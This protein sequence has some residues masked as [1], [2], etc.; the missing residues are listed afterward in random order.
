MD[1]SS[2]SGLLNN[3]VLL[4][5]LGVVYDSLGLHAIQNRNLR[6]SCS[7]FL[8]GLIG[9]AV[10][11]TPWELTP[12]IFFDTRWILLSLCGLFFGV[13][14]TLIAVAMTVSYRL[15]QGGGGQVVG[16]VVIVATAGV[17]LSWRYLSAKYQLHHNWWRLY[18]FGLAVELTFLSCMLLMPENVRWKIIFAVG[19][20]VLTIFPI[21][22]MLLGMILRRQ[23]ER[24]QAEKELKHN[25]EML[26]RER[27]LLRSLV[28]AIPD[29]IFFKD[30]ESIYLGCNK[31]FENFVGRSEEELK[32][33]SD[34]DLFDRDTAEFF[35]QKD[36]EMFATGKS[37]NNEE[38]VEYPD[39]RKVFLDTIKTTYSDQSGNIQGVVGISRDI[40]AKRKAE[41]LI[42]RQ[43][44]FDS[45]TGMPNRNMLHDRMVQEMK[46]ADRSETSM[47]VMF[48]DLDDFKDVN[49]TLGHD[50]GD[51][52]LKACAKR[53]S[54]CVRKADTVARQGGDEFTVILS[55]LTD[56]DSI[57]R[58]ANG[59]LRA[60]AE[61]FQLEGDVV[62]VTASIGITLYPQ[63]ADNVE[64]LQRNADQAM[65]EAKKRGR[66]RFQYFTRSMQEAAMARLILT[67]DLRDAVIDH[68]FK[69]LYQPIMELSSGTVHKAEA[70]IRWQ[71]P[72]RGLVSPLEFI[73]IAEETGMIVPMGNWIFHQSAEQVSQWRQRFGE[74]FQVSVNC[75]PVQFRDDSGSQDRWNEQLRKLKLPGDAIVVEITEGLLMDASDYV[76]DKLAAFAEANIQVA[77]DDFGTGYS[78]LSY[79]KRFDIDY[80]KIDRAFV[81]NLAP[82]SEDLALCEAIIVMAH[83]LGIKVIAEGIET[84]QQLQLLR[85][86]GCDFGQGYLF[87][88]PV[89]ARQFE[90][91]FEVR[92]IGQPV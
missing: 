66:G 4:L 25:R 91:L 51:T 88:P 8:I 57:E 7:G 55:E 60:V 20:T 75:S 56:P 53:L 49:D 43:A 48:L 69:V 73:S 78:S 32:R 2:F 46:K 40:T 89:A 6:D 15:F 1:T 87:S 17:G 68:Q 82:D 54:G 74:H 72:K 24:R 79:L 65:Y 50:K 41:E 29:L 58:V 92:K 5:A 63:D 70:L 31:A 44:N 61:P 37:L 67:N 34:F 19:P 36:R 26:G 16:S 81:S 35:R 22:T 30:R 52:L 12:G 80:L 28:N 42:W 90:E 3:A 84:E 85:E 38:W 77:L 62:Y 21:G 14:P 23:R 59:I 11:S 18:L 33:K 83:K 76:S 47:V 27:G 71:H 64:L 39:G 10:M 86:A 45:L 9:I 13:V